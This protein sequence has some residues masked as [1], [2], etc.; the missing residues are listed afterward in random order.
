MKEVME[1]IKEERGV[2]VPEE[3]A[4]V[5]TDKFSEAFG[6]MREVFSA[7]TQE[8]LDK[9]GVRLN[10]NEKENGNNDRPQ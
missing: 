8:K 7:I 2:A 3:Y 4:S 6:Q 1:E 10:N 9:E 5:F